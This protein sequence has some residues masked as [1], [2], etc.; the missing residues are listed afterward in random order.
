MDDCLVFGIKPGLARIKK[1]LELLGSPHRKIDFIHIVGTN[2]KTSTTTICANILYHHGLSSAFHISPHIS[3]YT[4]RIWI[5]GNQVSEELFTEAFNRI[6]PSV[7]RVNEMEP[8][9][10]MTQFEIIAGM[11]FELAGFM[12]VEVMVLEAG[13]G[14]RWDA[15][16]AADSVA[17][18]LTGVSL[19]HTEI[20]GDTV[21]EIAAE[22]AEVIK[23]G[24]SVATISVDP[25]V[26]KVIRDKAKETSSPVYFY[27]E[28]FRI[29]GQ[30]SRDF[31]G[32][33][34]DIEGIYGTYCG[35]EIPLLG[36]YQLLNT[37][38]A[39]VLAELYLHGK[40]G[41]IEIQKLRDAL[42]SV[43]VK[44]RFEIVRK[45]PLV[46]A[47]ASHNP[48]GMEKFLDNI[49]QY[50]PGKK[51]IVIFAVLKDK[52]FRKMI[53]KVIEAGNILILASSGSIRSLETGKLKKEVDSVLTM[54][55]RGRKSR[56]KAEEIYTVDSIENSLKFALKISGS[57]DIICITGSITN[58]ENL[59]GI[60]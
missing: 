40:G 60:Y 23:K 38:L 51:I 7:C 33:A 11:G 59:K 42:S 21:A 52:D 27:P 13:M 29:P 8:G 53:D 36:K 10:P 12:D 17:V 55:K 16:N 9:G 18:G 19:E 45:K 46:V 5:N 49:R 37:A 58:L 24:S 26:R 2:G 22:K 35:L 57:N 43:R 3:G 4:D 56:V 31:N 6:Y 39:V 34:M 32:W 44:G 54:K 25:E 50:F 47:D 15:T 1:L 30:E 20:L 28:N 41:R 14:G 48:E